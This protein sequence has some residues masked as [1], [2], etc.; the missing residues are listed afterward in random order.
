MRAQPFYEEIEKPSS[1]YTSHFLSADTIVPGYTNPQSLN[2][3]S[4]VTNNPLKYTDPTGHMQASDD[5]KDSDGKC[6][7]GDK[8]CNQMKAKIKRKKDQSRGQTLS[9]TNPYIGTPQNL[10]AYVSG[11]WVGGGVPNHFG[12]MGYV[13]EQE[14]DHVY[15]AGVNAGLR[16]NATYSI[17]FYEN[18][19][20]L[21]ITER[22]SLSKNTEYT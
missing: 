19:A 22:Y 18:G 11:I 1:P 17:G 10:G 20:Q 15:W 12:V 9:G 14:G 6:D 7:K 16:Y 21:N 5:Y 8:A 13:P 4:Y 2:R 3:Y